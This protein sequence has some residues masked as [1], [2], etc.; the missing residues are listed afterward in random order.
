[1]KR[2]S[3]FSFLMVF[4]LFSVQSVNALSIW[5]NDITGVI[6]WSNQ[7]QQHNEVGPTE[8]NV[9]RVDVYQNYGNT[10][11]IL[12]STNETGVWMNWTSDVY[13]SPNTTAISATWTTVSFIWN[14][15]YGIQGTVVA[16][17]VFI[18]G[19][20]YAAEKSTTEKTF[21]VKYSQGTMNVDSGYNE[22]NFTEDSLNIVLNASDNG[23]ITVDV[24]TTTPTEENATNAIVY[25]NITTNVNVTNITITWTYTDAQLD[26]LGI[27][28]EDLTFY[29]WNAETEQWEEIETTVDTATKTITAHLYHF[30]YYAVGEKDKD[31]DDGICG[32]TILIGLIMIPTGIIARRLRTGTKEVG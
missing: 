2:I 26:L 5:G 10:E 29:Y 23:L 21:Y 3:L 13:S 7:S 27:S 14:N 9:L 20:S 31:S 6:S 32:P 17:K 24:T 1:M 16:W 19:T 30:S 12:L 28:A 11:Y 8:S 22:I 15:F 25:L 4:S 18:N